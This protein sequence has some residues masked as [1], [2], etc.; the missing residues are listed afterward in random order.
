MKEADIKN[1]IKVVDMMT[2]MHSVLAHRFTCRATVL[3]ICVL[4]F[5]TLLIS[6]TF[7][8]SDLI[9]SLGFTQN[10]VRV[11]IG[12]TAIII[13]F[14]STVSLVVNWKGK[15]VQHRDGFNTLL[16]IKNELRSLLSSFEDFS[17]EE[18]KNI[19]NRCS[20]IT[21]Q[22]IPIPDNDFNKLKAYHYR[23]VQLS[24][25][26]SKNP[27]ASVIVLRLKLMFCSDTKT[28]S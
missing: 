16:K 24:K 27:G 7:V 2:T 14:I 1:Q 15:G 4:A 8:D 3:D 6:V 20:L 5:S 28:L 19:L 21:S 17:D 10:N 12:F 25:M 11:S 23:K 26:I 13:F 22:I 18:K 9:A